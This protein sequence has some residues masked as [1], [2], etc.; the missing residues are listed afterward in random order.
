MSTAPG[1]AED[2]LTEFALTVDDLA[3]M[4][5]AGVF[6]RE[7]SERVELVDGRLVQMA[8]E[9]M[10]HIR[11]IQRLNL[12]LVT[13]VAEAGLP[14]EVLPGGTLRVSDRTALDPDL[15]VVAEGLS[16]TFASVE[17]TRL[18]VEV[19]LST[20]RRDLGAKSRAYAAAGVQE[21]W[22]VDLRNATLHVHRDAESDG[23]WRN[24]EKVSVGA[25]EPLFAP[26]ARLDIATFL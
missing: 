16:T 7:G 14:L 20:L 6:D 25:V 8:P 2:G 21:Y 10:P 19:S 3:A 17:A 5:D 18:V 13:L 4:M 9:S 11:T 22:V 26:G 15:L 12:R 24:V 23:R 1:F